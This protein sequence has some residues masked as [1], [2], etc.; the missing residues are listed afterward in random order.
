MNIFFSQDE[1]NEGFLKIQDALNSLKPRLIGRLSGF[2][3]D[4]VGR[5]LAG[6]P[7]N[8]VFYPFLEN[9][10]GIKISNDIDKN[11]YLRLY[12]NAVLNC[13]VQ[14]NLL[15]IWDGQMAEQSSHLINLIKPYNNGNLIAAH[16][17]EPYYFFEHEEYILPEIFKGKKILII[18][19]H[20]S[21][22]E[23][24]IPKLSKIWGE[25]NFFKKSEFV[26]YRPPCQFAGS[27][28]GNSWLGHYQKMCED[29]SRLDFDL[30]LVS[31]GGF[32][33]ITSDFIYK[34]GK[35]AVHVGGPLQLF[36]GIKGSRWK[37][38]ETIKKYQ[39][40]YWIS[41]LDVDKPKFPGIVEGGCYW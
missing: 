19:S 12:E 18:S 21:S 9:N 30:A 40:E 17:L 23:E 13:F 4:F 22:I 5:E 10:A 6:Y 1:K 20:K 25:R 16:S 31:C 11:Y 36:F 33:L 28:D 39:N 27:G 38:N 14:G 26:V 37:N 35:T 34:I 32:G 41:P 2:E 3:T 7:T 8:G 29:L 15:G 24:Q